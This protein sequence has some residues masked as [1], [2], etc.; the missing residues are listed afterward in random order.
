MKKEPMK[1]S[2]NPMIQQEALRLALLDKKAPKDKNGKPLKVKS[3]KEITS[4]ENQPALMWVLSQRK[5]SKNG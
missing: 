5:R 3:K 2:R 4:R 1:L